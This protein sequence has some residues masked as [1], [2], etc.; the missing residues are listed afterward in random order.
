MKP[1]LLVSLMISLFSFSA[2]C[3]QP[4]ATEVV[5]KANDLM[6]GRSSQSTATMTIVAA[7][8]DTESK[9]ENMVAW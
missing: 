2:H 9:H 8:L 3:Q 6:N 1:L 7:Y 4:D 5:R